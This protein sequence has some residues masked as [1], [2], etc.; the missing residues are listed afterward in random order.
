MTCCIVE[1]LSLTFLDHPHTTCDTKLICRLCYVV[2]SDQCLG[3]ASC[4]STAVPLVPAFPLLAVPRSL[5]LR[6]H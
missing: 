1:N 5:K 6:R 4:P 3:S 2:W